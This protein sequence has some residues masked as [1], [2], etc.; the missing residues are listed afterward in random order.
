MIC[1]LFGAALLAASAAPRFTGASSCRECHAAAYELQRA[2]AHARALSPIQGSVLAARLLQAG[3][4]RE[5]RIRYVYEQAEGG[6]RA[7]VAI[8]GETATMLLEWAFGAG[9]QAYTA[10]GRF[11]QS[12]IEHR[13]SY[14]SEARRFSLTPGHLGAA[15]LS[16]QDALG[17]PQDERTLRRC[18]GC[19]ATAV[20][21]AADGV[22]LS[23]M[24]PGVRCE[25]CH[26]PGSDHIEAARQG[27]IAKAR[28]SVLNPGRFSA[29]NIV[30]ICGECHRTPDPA[31]LSPAPEMDD[32]LS[33]RFQ[34]VGLMASRCFESSGKLSCLSCHDAHGPLRRDP[35][36]YVAVC[37]GCHQRAGPA[38]QCR[39]GEGANCLPCH[40]P[41][42]EPAPHLRFR[43]HR[44]RV[45][46][47]EA[48]R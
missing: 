12:W 13:I 45:A 18:F 34:P 7:S 48:A 38:K 28:Q 1:V 30:L 19:H 39:R 32:P 44:I 35:E 42:A 36:H 21:A 22:D 15:T 9:S 41:E 46:F 6:V 29:K 24:E 31:R 47:A 33:V 14:Y 26:G 20:R 10:V 2:T 23:Q 25:R 43:D 40:M 17:I 4:I 16:A 8:E 37:L 27:A 3:S 5:G 11:E